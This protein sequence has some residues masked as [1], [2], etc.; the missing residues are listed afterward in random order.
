MCFIFALFVPVVAVSAVGAVVGAAVVFLNLFVKAVAAAAFAVV[1][2]AVVVVSIAVE[3]V[4]IGGVFVLTWD[5]FWRLVVFV[6]VVAVGIVAVGV[7]VVDVLLVE[8]VIR[9]VA[10]VESVF[11][12][13]VEED[14]LV[15]NCWL[16]LRSIGSTCK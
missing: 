14:V 11:V 15:V 12:V 8:A 1:D 9:T 4:A 6:I 5:S 3:V 13:A 10:V 16:S 2:V 7:A